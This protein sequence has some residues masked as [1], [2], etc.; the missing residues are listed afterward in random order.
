MERADFVDHHD[1]EEIT[2]GREE[3]SIQVVLCSVADGAA[4][5]IENNLAHDEEENAK[6]DVPERPSILQGCC[7]KDHLGDDIDRKEDGIDQVKH[8]KES[9]CTCGRQAPTLERHKR[10]PAG[11]EEHADR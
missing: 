4:E 1:S 3:E 11:Q 7:D 9:E 6:A 8:H 5:N 2:D 10:D